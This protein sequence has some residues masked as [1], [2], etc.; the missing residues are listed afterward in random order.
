MNEVLLDVV[1]LSIEF[2][3]HHGWVRAVNEL[4]FQVRDGEIFG[5]VGESGCGKSVTSLAILRLLNSDTSR[6]AS[7]QI[8]FRGRDI[9]TMT[10]DEL[11][12]LRGGKIAMIFQDSMTSLNPVMTIGDQL[13]SSLLA[14]TRISRQQARAKA[15]ELLKTVQIPSPQERA[16][17]YPHQLSGGM[18]QRVM[19]AL[20]LIN[21]PSLLIADEPTTALDVTVQAQ[22]LDLLAKLQRERAMSVI[23]ITHDM[24]VVAEMAHRV[25]VMYAGEKV[26]CGAQAEVFT[27]SAHPYTQ[28]LIR[29]IP[30]IDQSAVESLYTIPGRVPGLHEMPE[31]CRFAPRCPHQMPICTAEHPPQ[32]ELFD[33]HQCMCWLYRPQLSEEMI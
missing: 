19:I 3:T 17:E 23:L 24:G 8:R 33:G 15:V 30:M 6:I 4:S 13:A 29:A 32:F 31:G 21:E 7:G 14:H 9:L 1:D 22:I 12:D 18:R 16:D 2:Y 11:R 25:M 5:I 28:G 27:R 20:A 10:K 26:E